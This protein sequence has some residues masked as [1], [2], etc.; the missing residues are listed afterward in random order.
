M[1]WRL[2]TVNTHTTTADFTDYM[3]SMDLCPRGLFCSLMKVKNPEC[4]ACTYNVALIWSH[5]II[6]R[7]LG[8]FLK[9]YDDKE[10]MPVTPADFMWRSA[11]Q[12]DD[13]NNSRQL[14]VDGRINGAVVLQRSRAGFTYENSVWQSLT[15][16]SRCQLGLLVIYRLI[17][18][19]KCGKKWKE[20]ILYC[21]PC[22]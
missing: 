13:V 1:F 21:F 7:P 16:Q 9:Q 15:D 22:R 3:F 4:P 14:A 19:R 5:A 17:S 8:V 20:L 18:S 6:K 10:H 12:N 11:L 2:V